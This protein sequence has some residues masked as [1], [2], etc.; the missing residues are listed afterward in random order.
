[1]QR[2]THTRILDGDMNTTK[3]HFDVILHTHG[4]FFRF[5]LLQGKKA[6]HSTTKYCTISDK[7][8]DKHLLYL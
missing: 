4:F 7:R 3:T 1:M 6:T 8:S 2:H 5:H